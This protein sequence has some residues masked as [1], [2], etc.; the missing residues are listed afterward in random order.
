MATRYSTQIQ[1]LFTQASDFVSGMG[2][3][4]AT[5]KRSYFTRNTT[6]SFNGSVAAD[7]IVYLA[8]IPKGAR[9]VGGVLKTGA[10]GANNVATVGIKSVAS[11][12]T[13]ST[14]DF[15]LGSTSVAA[16]SSTPFAQTEALGFGYVAT[17]ELFLTVT[18]T[19]GT[20]A[21]DKNILGYIE[22]LYN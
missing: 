8:R 12:G 4:N 17:E 6:D 13:V 11:A 14:A 9:V 3:V 15:F 5:T 2:E 21:G 10:L 22:Y 1:P 20:V 18:V 16:I 19:T 7:D